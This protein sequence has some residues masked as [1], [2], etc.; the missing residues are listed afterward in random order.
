MGNTG[1]RA[2]EI[3]GIQYN[4]LKKC[5]LDYTKKAD[6]GELIP[7]LPHFLASLPD[8]VGE[9]DL[10]RYLIEHRGEEGEY[11]KEIRLVLRI[12][13]W[14]RGQYLSNPAWSGASST[15]AVL[16]LG[17]DYGDGVRY[18]AKERDDGPAG[19][20]VRFGDSEMSKAAGR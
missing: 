3:C 6:A 8:Y 17:K 18:S 12:L 14:F 5:F 4:A 15:K 11:T 10:Q 20:Q 16:A 19:L 13:Q 2:G 7:S 1:E 9:D